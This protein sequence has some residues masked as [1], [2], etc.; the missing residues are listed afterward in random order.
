[1]S[2]LLKMTNAQCTMEGHTALVALT[3]RC[4]CL[5]A[6][7]L[8]KGNAP[9]QMWTL[10]MRWWWWCWTERTS[11]RE[12]VDEINV[13]QPFDVTNVHRVVAIALHM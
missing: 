13:K 12:Q 8:V 5:L 9:T 4:H 2:V 11:L 10:Q 6:F 1:M 7:F 3:H